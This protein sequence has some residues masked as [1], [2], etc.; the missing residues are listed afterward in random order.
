MTQSSQLRERICAEFGYFFGFAFREFS[1]I[2]Y[3]VCQ[4]GLAKPDQSV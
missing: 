1:C 4:A 3:Q 2:A